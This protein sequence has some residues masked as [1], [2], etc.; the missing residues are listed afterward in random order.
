MSDA[1]QYRA[2]A[3]HCLRMAEDPLNWDHKRTWL[4]MAETWLGII[5]QAQREPEGMY[6]KAG[7]YQ[8]MQHEPS[9]S[10]H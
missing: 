6:E 2:N 1:D 10:L 4:N 8:G 9:K 3:I 5:R 7:Q